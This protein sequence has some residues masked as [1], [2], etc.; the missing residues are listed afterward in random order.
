MM[1][2]S[3]EISST[4]PWLSGVGWGLIQGRLG[5]N[6]VIVIIVVS[7]IIIVLVMA[8]VIFIVIP[9]PSTRGGRHADSRPT[10]ARFENQVDYCLELVI[11]VE[12]GTMVVSVVV[13]MVIMLILA[14]VIVIATFI[15][16]ID[17][18]ANASS[19]DSGEGVGG[20]RGTD[21]WYNFSS[22]SS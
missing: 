16:M 13:V 9:D 4:Q 2:L 17:F 12:E 22:S 11:S 6:I 19:A 14:S 10:Y 8:M 15:I 21:A 20:K 5:L 3:Q 7:V 18:R 1:K